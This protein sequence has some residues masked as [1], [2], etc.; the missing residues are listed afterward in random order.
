MNTVSVEILKDLYYMGVND[1]ET[2]LFENMWPLPEGV[3]YNSYLITDE[4]TALLDTVK[5]T[6]VDGFIDSLKDNLGGRNL[7]YLVVHH[8]EPDHSGCIKTVRDLYP[9]VTIV[10]NKKTKSMMSDYLDIEI[11]N[12]VEVKDGD[13]LDLGNRKLT[14]VNTPMVHWP[15]SM[16]SYESTDKILFSQDIFGGFGALNGTIF[17]DE[18]NF[19]FFQ[20][21]MRR[22]YSNIVGKYSKQAAKALQKVKALDINIICPVH[23]IVWR[24][25]PD[26]IVDEYIKYA[27]QVNEEG[28]VIA[29]GSMYG[30]T[31]KM[32]DYLARFLAEEGIKNVKVFDVS[33]THVSYI[34]SEIWKY[35]G[36]IIGSC[37]YNNSVYPN[38]NQ[39]LYTLKM[40]KLN[41]HVLG[42]FGSYGWS[43]GAVKELSEFASEGGNF[44]VVPTVVETKGTM[45]EDDVEGLKKMAKEMAGL[46]KAE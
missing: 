46:L 17:D 32:A 12:F 25:N 36:V 24:T 35:K 18:M 13:T 39:L 15:E 33:K 40:N 37:T 38:V 43:G 42:I 8:M 41:N 16:V 2:N 19:E 22:Y 45:K 30:N 27:N 4:K 6:K 28:V 11:G 29:Y 26:R 44:E 9:E 31:E 5:I 23:G 14:F 3:A 10:G 34:L 21:E 7:D 1:R 20:D